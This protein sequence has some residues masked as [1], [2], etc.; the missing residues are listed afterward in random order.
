MGF[1]KNMFGRG[2]HRVT[3]QPSMLEF[4]VGGGQSVLEAALAQGLAFPHSCTVGTCGACKCRLVEGRIREISNFAYVLDGEELRKGIILAC[5]AAP[6]SD[7]LLEVPGLSG[8]RLHPWESFTGQLRLGRQFTHDIREVL[9]ELDRPMRFD[10]GQYATLE[11]AQVF[12]SRAYSIANPPEPAGV[13][14][15]R[16]IIR[17]VP[18]GEFTGAL[19][20][21]RLDGTQCEVRGPLG[22]FWLRESRGPLIAMAGGSG[23]APLLSM[24]KDAAAHG[25]GRDCLMLFG[26]RT[27]ADLYALDELADIAASW[28]GALRVVPVLSHEDPA[29]G[30]SG[31]RGLVTDALDDMNSTLSA[32]GA[33][34]YLSG[35]PAMV[36]AATAALTAG[37]LAADNIHC[38]K[39]LDGRHGLVR[40]SRE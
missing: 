20:G 29:S 12:G 33:E 13:G 7:L 4:E 16:F 14:T 10:A 17:H 40:T 22:N 9:V 23:L 15:L 24:L 38:D 6:R 26:A 3:A 5:Q 8:R 31:A 18:D 39:F 25:V 28:N 32:P 1:L 30:W 2:K 21:G 35:P 36:D 34:A 27:Q 37:G 11:T 19:F